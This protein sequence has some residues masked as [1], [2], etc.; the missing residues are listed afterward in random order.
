[1]VAGWQPW[2]G[3]GGR[4]AAVVPGGAGAAPVT[5]SSAADVNGKGRCKAPDSLGLKMQLQP[6]KCMREPSLERDCLNLSLL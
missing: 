3:R 4:V 5:A 6:A 2:W 1:M